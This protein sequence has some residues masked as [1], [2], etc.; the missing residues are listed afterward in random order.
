M[1]AIHLEIGPSVIALMYRPGPASALGS[2]ASARSRLGVVS[3][4]VKVY[5]GPTRNSC[6]I[7]CEDGG[8]T[9]RETL[10]PAKRCLVLS[11]EAQQS[12]LPTHAQTTAAGDD[13][14]ETHHHA[15][16]GRHTGTHAQGWQAV[17]TFLCR[18]ARR[19]ALLLSAVLPW[20]RKK[21]SVLRS[22]L[23][24]FGRFTTTVSHFSPPAPPSSRS[25]FGRPAP[26]LDRLLVRDWQ[27]GRTI[28][29]SS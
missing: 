18:P 24:F 7:A 2:K 6:C 21:L 15:P 25:K 14:R 4:I 3:S 17:R 29:P 27:D 11:A 12:C 1:P 5:G 10:Q 19:R 22:K 8:R 23:L 13:R 20:R 28:H 16:G 26:G 9:A